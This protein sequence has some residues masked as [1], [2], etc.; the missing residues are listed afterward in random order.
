MTRSYAHARAA[1]GDAATRTFSLLTLQRAAGRSTEV[2]WLTWDGLKWDVHFTHVFGEWPQSKGSK[3]K[4][5]CFGA[6]RVRALCWFLALADYLICQ[7]DR[8]IYS[9]AFER[10]RYPAHDV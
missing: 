9:G 8:E 10:D 6:A 4:L 3:L 7:P 5:G 1:V 2:A